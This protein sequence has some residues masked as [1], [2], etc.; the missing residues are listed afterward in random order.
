MEDN[1]IQTMDEWKEL[2]EANAAAQELHE[3]I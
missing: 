1:V 2:E 3:S